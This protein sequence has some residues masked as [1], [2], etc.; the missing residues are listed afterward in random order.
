MDTTPKNVCDHCGASI[1][2]WKHGLTRG[3]VKAFIKF[4]YA[5][6]K[7]EYNKIHLQTEMELTKN[8]YNNFQKLRYFGLV[9]RSGEAGNWALTNIGERYA[10]GEIGIEKFAISYR[11]R[12]VRREGEKVWL[13]QFYEKGNNT[14]SFDYWQQSFAFTIHEGE[15]IK[16]QV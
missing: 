7:K 15:V 12:L 5:I 16:Y 13:Q 9:A 2:E 10:R 1:K 14:E 11:D 3:L 8:E 6:N 4:C